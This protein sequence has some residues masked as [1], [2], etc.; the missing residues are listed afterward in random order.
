MFSTSR[1]RSMLL[2]VA[3]CGWMTAPAAVAEQRPLMTQ[4]VREPARS[5]HAQ[6]AVPKDTVLRFDML[7]PVRAPA[8]LERFLADVYNPASPH[9]RQFVSPAEFTTRFGPAE[10]DWNELVAFAKQNG[11]TIVGGSRDEMDLRLAGTVHAIEAAFH[12]KMLV[13]QHPTEPRT[14]YGPDADWH[15]SGLDNFSRPHARLHARSATAAK[16][17][18][19]TGACPGNS[20]C[21]SDMRA[22]YYGGTA[23]TGAGQSIGL[24]EFYGYDTADL[25]AYFSTAGQTNKVPVNGISTDGSSVNCVYA[26]GCDDG[27]QTL[28]ITQAL[29]MAPG[30][31]QLNVYVGGTDTAVLSAMSVPPKGSVTGK[32]DAQLSCSWGWGPAD[33]ATDDPLFKK[34]AAQGQS[35]FTAAGDSGAYSSNSQYIFPADDANVTVVGGTDLATA[36]PGGAWL[37]ESAW[38]DGGGGYFAADSIP[39]P[40]WQQAAVA[41]LNALSSQHASTTFRNSPDVS[42]EANFDFY[43]CADQKPCV[44]NQWGG[45]SFAAPMWAGYMALVNQQAAQNGMASVGFLNPAIYALAASSSAYAKSFHDVAAGSNGY[46]A[47]PGYDLATGLGSPNGA[48][49]IAALATPP[50]PGFSLATAGTLAVAQAASGS[51]TLTSSVTGG[52]NAPIALAASGAPAGVSLSFNPAS[53]NGAGSSTLSV[54][55]AQSVAA[56]TYAIVITGTSSAGASS[57]AGKPA[58]SPASTTVQLT[59]TVPNFSLS[60]TGSLNVSAPGTAS[61]NV[62]STATGGFSGTIALQAAGAPS[63]V[64]LAFS[65]TAI[66]GG[67]ASSLTAQVGA[68]TPAGVYPLTITGS[69]GSLSH[70]VSVMLTVTVP[71]FTLASSAGAVSLTQGLSN[72]V[73]LAATA[74]GGFNGAVA[75]AATGSP[76]G[77]AVGF[78]PSSITGSGSSI[79]TFKA[80]AT[81]APGSYSIVLT[82]TSG[83]LQKS[84]T[85]VV[86]VG[87]ASLSLASPTPSLNVLQGASTSVSLTTAATGV[88][89]APVT[90]TASGVPSGVSAAFSATSTTPPA[91]VTLSFVVGATAVAGTYPVTV[92]GTSG[93]V[94][95]KLTLTLVVAAPLRPSFVFAV[96]ATALTLTHGTSTTFTVQSASTGSAS[97][98]VALSQTGLPAGVTAAF[99]ATSISGTGAAVVTLTAAPTATHGTSVASFS[100]T[101]A[102]ATQTST[103]ALTV[104]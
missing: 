20:Y 79:V 29:G 5:A 45:T 72:T 66:T 36:G 15:I 25:T 78:S 6:G 84:T 103:V 35:F 13:F 32:V 12:V 54:Q 49:L 28:D 59:V 88:L 55:V 40:A 9:Y 39:I 75:L 90:L 85:V 104:N 42:A 24:V 4:H 16:P 86:S 63:G 41:G 11:F 21:G 10:S 92:T 33:P 102:G 101:A 17:L 31:S 98:T 48:G 62:A 57:V 65:P 83:M 58:V 38:S 8:D 97:V 47:V 76:N 22:A 23:L 18:T 3:L 99:S 56:G 74:T 26:Q 95:A 68:S 96:G 80:A 60:A 64:S 87:A 94:T 67:A 1:V 70:S 82:G 53:I 93:S 73:T 89:A 30:L 52:F 34:F 7:L 14:Y 44:S 27:E 50:T 61:V 91:S 81:T 69:S 19:T 77:L 2:A 51:I 43:T 46:P 71:S 100:G 37:Y